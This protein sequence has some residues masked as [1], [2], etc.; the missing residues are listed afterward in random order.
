MKRQ[1][2]IGM[3]PACL[4]ALLLAAAGGATAA[5]AAEIGHIGL[6]P[7]T[8]QEIKD[9]KLTGAQ[10]SG[11]MV[12]VGIGQPAYLEALVTADI[13]AS[14]IVDVIWALTSRPIGSTAALTD[15]PLG[16]NVPTFKQE[17]RELYQVASRKLLRPDVTGQYVVSATVITATETNTLTRQIS[18]ATYMG[19]QNC[20]L[21][22]SGGIAAENIYTPWSQTK[23]ATAFQKAIDGISTDH[24]GKNCISCHVVGFD[25]NAAAVNGGFDD[26]ALQTGWQFPTNA[27]GSNYAAMP[28]A[29]RNVA[30]IQC[31]SCHGP[32]SEHA[33]AFGNT[34]VANWPRIGTTLAAGSC[35]Q[36][37]DSL[38]HHYKSAEW[39]NS[40]HA[41][42][43]EE[44]ESGC[45]RC[46]SAKGFA[47][48]A[49]GAPATATP[50]DVITCAA[51][52]DPHD[53][54]N[55]GQLRT[56]AP[57][58][59]ADKKTTITKDT[60]GLG[61][62]CMNCHI[63]RRDATNYVE[64]TA[65][66]NRYGPHHGPQTDMFVGANAMNYGLDI[67]SSAHR[68][69]LGESCLE[70]HMQSVASTNAAFTK[71]GGHSFNMSATT[72]NGV[73]HLTEACKECHGEIE[74][75]DF[76]RLDYDGNGVV[77]G[78]QTEVKGLLTKLTE[79]LPCGRI[80]EHTA[81]ALG[82]TSKWTKPQLRAG[83]NYLFVVEDGSWGVHNLSYAVGLLKASIA[84]LTG[85]ANTDSLPDS[86]QVQYFGSANNPSAAPNATPAGDGI[87]NWMKYALGLDPTVAGGEMPG[88]VVFANG[89]NLV[90]PPINPG[91]TNT[92]A[93]FTAAEIVFNSEVGK[94]YQIQAITAVTAAW[95]DVG[96][97]IPGTGAPI[98]FVAPTRN[99]VQMY[100]R[101]VAK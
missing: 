39:N 68:D 79:L 91:E 89:K 101:V 83:Y 52:H 76:K 35:S 34:N 93:I 75:F 5:L 46:H 66:S 62:V 92:I 86:W 10:I 8:P 70:C 40:K 55:P 4:T 17:E 3:A 16:A 80:T 81:T 60:A 82:I 24:F 56:V 19:I 54:T 27:V 87:P 38:S 14:S 78:V 64:I 30:N 71:A 74:S 88:G 48:Y 51:C 31:E 36:C 96:A 22:H 90:N 11:G 97:P 23:H 20:A 32:G 58:T 1:T 28:A 47:N 21:C 18:G 49:A 53:A 41:R 95:E 9:Y 99:K 65:G 85:D 43:V 29:L 59:L 73:V 94:S 45:A 44:T 2:L 63:S 98:S 77:D 7:L 61:I 26:L 15:S 37:H 84:S 57:V 69:V 33:A 6:R 100:Y 42:A 72:T 13:P 25:T 12:A 67:P 50:Y